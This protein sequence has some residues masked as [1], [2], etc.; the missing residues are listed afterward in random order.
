[1]NHARNSQIATLIVICTGVLW[2]L[3][4]VPVRQLTEIG[5]PGAWGTFAI[6]MAAV[7]LLL[8]A[9]MRD[10]HRI[11][12]THPI[13]LFAILLGGCAFA[14]YSIGFVYGRVA[15]IVLLFFLSP[16]WSTLIG[17]YIMG[18]HTPRMRIAAIGTGLLGL[19]IMLS[20]DGTLPFPRN[21]GEWMGLISGILW[22]IS[23]T[24]MKAKSTLP[25]GAAAFVFALGATIISL[26][27]APFLEPIPTIAKPGQTAGLAFAAGGLWWGVMMVGLMW[28]TVRLE[29]ARV[30][31]LLMSE[32]IIGAASAAIWA[33]EHL[34]TTEILGG[35]FVLLAG[36]LEVWPTKSRW[37][38]DKG[39]L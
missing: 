29:P 38:P 14:L 7:V 25:P 10:H 5:L 6:T 26:I 17:R 22:S 34:N 12:N 33:G 32:V 2:G 35:A 20:A 21:T 15:I 3:Y 9:A 27:L 31:I 37:T 39:T 28:A 1:M 18:W 13:A 16:V 23:T 4:W 11:L 24:G 36:V 8:P 30:G 19:G